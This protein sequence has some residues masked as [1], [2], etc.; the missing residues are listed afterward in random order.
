M[1]IVVTDTGR[2]NL[3]NLGTITPILFEN[4]LIISLSKDW[5][6]K[7]SGVPKFSVKINE[8]GR[9]CITSETPVENGV[10]KFE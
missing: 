9:L 6:S 10:D 7:F 2:T 4:N 8:T 3:T 5:I 1:P